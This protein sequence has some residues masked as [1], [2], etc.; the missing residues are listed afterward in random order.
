MRVSSI[1]INHRERLA[2]KEDELERSRTSTRDDHHTRYTRE[3]QRHETEKTT[4][5]YE[6]ED[7]EEVEDEQEG[8]VVEDEEDETL[9]EDVSNGHINQSRDEEEEV[10]EDEHGEEEEEEEEEES[11]EELEAPSTPNGAKHVHFGTPSPPATPPSEE[12]T[13]PHTPPS[14]ATPLTPTSP[15]S[16]PPTTPSNS[17]LPSNE[18]EHDRLQNEW[19]RRVASSANKYTHSRIPLSSNKRLYSESPA[20]TPV[21]PSILPSLHLPLIFLWSSLILTI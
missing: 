13:P 12:T 18:A 17:L 19:R 7:Q 16:S 9:E 21:T 15:T 3:V 6:E 20:R 4:E 11:N 1:N 14:A 5:G 2:E 8:E 10:V